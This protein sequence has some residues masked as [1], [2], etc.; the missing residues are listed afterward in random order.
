MTVSLRKSN[1]RRGA[2]GLR[3]ATPLVVNDTIRICSSCGRKNRV[4]LSHLADVG[5]CGA[6]KQP[7]PALA[8][9][10]E[11]GAEQFRAITRS[12]KVPVLVDFWAE[13]CGP[14]RM[15][16][17]EI[18]QVARTMSGKAIV[19]KVNTETNP[20]LAQQFQ[21]RGIP[22]FAVLKNGKVVLEQAGLVDR[23]QMQRWLEQAA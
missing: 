1:S 4:P 6:C 12:A 13:W 7:L 15:A 5:S 21:I 18:E 23:R 11:V 17:P 16:A 9:P 10:L 3:F 20:D 22:T 2:S 14:C 19:L 8:K